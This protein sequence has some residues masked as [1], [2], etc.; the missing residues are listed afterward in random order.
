MSQAEELLNSLAEIEEELAHYSNNG[1][2]I[3]VNADRTITVPNEL[4]SIAVQYDNNVETVTFDCP[5]YWDEHD[6]ST[7]NIYINYRC[8]DGHRGRYPVKNLYVDDENNEI[9][10]FDWTIS[11][12]VT[13]VS[14]KLSFLVCAK[15]TETDALPHWNS[16]M[17]QDLTIEPGMEIYDEGTV[18]QNPELI[19][20]MLT[21]LD[22]L[23]TANKLVLI[24]QGTQHQYSLCILNGKL[25]MVEREV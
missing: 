7:M 2:H 22:N 19:E 13:M 10:H 6:F 1:F 11:N 8:P 25:M 5:R 3:V 23:E 12:D 4:K 14:G 18:K 15:N 20:S 16:R 17:N 9:I 21:R 24:D